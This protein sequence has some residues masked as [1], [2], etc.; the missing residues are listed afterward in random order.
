VDVC[1]ELGAT[2]TRTGCRADADAE[3]VAAAAVASPRLRLVGVAGYEAALGQDVSA[4]GVGRVRDYLAWVRAVATRLASVCEVAD[5]TVLD[6]RG[7]V[8]EL[9]RTFF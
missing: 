7:R 1:V 2:G 6:E 4:A 9:V 3:A 5:V 8:I